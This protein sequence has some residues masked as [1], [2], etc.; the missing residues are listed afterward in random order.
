M[1]YILNPNAAFAQVYQLPTRFC[2]RQLIEKSRGQQQP[3]AFTDLTKGFD[4]SPPGQR[5]IN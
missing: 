1:N 2:V 5:F 4:Q 3:L